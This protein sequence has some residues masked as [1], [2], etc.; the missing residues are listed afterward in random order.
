MLRLISRR[1]L[2]LIPIIIGVT[3]I[4]FGI[5]RMTPGDPAQIL[6]GEDASLEDIESIRKQFGLDKP[7]LLQ[8]A[9]YLG[10]LVQGD[11]GV[12]IRTQRTVLSE[13]MA[14]YPATLELAGLAVLVATV[15]GL[16]TGIIAAK[17]QNS[18]FDYGSMV[19]S[20]FG[21]SM[22]SFWLG[23]MLMLIF[24]VIL[25][26]FPAVG[27]GGFSHL[28]LPAISLGANSAA[29]IA[30]MT[31]SSMLEVIRQDYIRTAR[32]KGLAE[33]VVLYK[34]AVRNAL[35]P[36]VTV[37]GIQFG[38][39]LS[40]AILTETVF[41]WPGV[42]RMIVQAI[43]TRDYPLVQGAILFVAINFTLVNLFV[44]LLYGYINPRLRVE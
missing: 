38:Y 8:Y 29:I 20:L 23:L 13:I 10:N 25:G 26:W 5:M 24:A 31:R 32:A 9:I 43:Y 11:M 19:V 27:R 7:F 12:S 30:R 2:Y 18:F 40:G 35:I 16:V 14:R 33:R 39:M 41:A 15:L 22:P 21:I 1:L 6:A 3:F 34:H 44:D 4:S 36:V 42:G 37:V 17:N 28:V